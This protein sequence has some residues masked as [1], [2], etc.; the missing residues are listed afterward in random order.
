MDASV[1]DVE[2]VHD[3]RLVVIGEDIA[4][5]KL[6]HDAFDGNGY[7]NTLNEKSC[8]DEKDDLE[9]SD[10]YKSVNDWFFTP[11]KNPGKTGACR[12]KGAEEKHDVDY[13]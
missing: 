11:F 1:I 5:N 7:Y 8:D 3:G 4:D 2:Y 12:G 9:E 13:L 6:E 10:R